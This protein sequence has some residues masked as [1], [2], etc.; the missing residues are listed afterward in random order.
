MSKIESDIKF[1]ERT[2]EI[3][4]RL[5]D[6]VY[7]RKRNGELYTY[8]YEHKPKYAST[9]LSRR[10]G[11]INKVITTMIDPR[12]Q[13]F[14][15]V[16]KRVFYYTPYF[17]YPGAYS[18]TCNTF[19]KVSAKGEYEVNFNGMSSISKLAPRTQ[20]KF[21][22]PQTGIYTLQCGQ[23]GK[24]PATRE[25][26]VIPSESDLEA[27]Y[28]EWFAVHLSEILEL[29]LPDFESMTIYRAHLKGRD[30]YRDLS[31]KADD[32]MVLVK[33][34]DPAVM[35][36]RRYVNNSGNA[37]SQYFCAVYPHIT[38]C[39]KAVSPEFREVWKQYHQNWYHAHYPENDKVFWFVQL[40]TR[41]LFKAAAELG[42]DLLQLSPENWLPGIETLGDLIA[43]AGEGNYGLSQEELQ[44]TFGVH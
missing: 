16:A 4:G 34:R 12:K 44:T 6:T 11:I 5:V 22:F 19:F 43:A 10:T 8:E 18:F 2:C 30:I 13:D 38:E 32:V 17:V 1:L 26:R 20:L 14:A 40:W 42:F 28:L 27:A 15:E 24:L 33:S 36:S 37:Q 7:R 23:E 31:G 21:S 25:I 39:W 9:V 35:Y 41:I 29:P 3:H